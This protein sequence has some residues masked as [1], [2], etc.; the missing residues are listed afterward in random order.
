MKSVNIGREELMFDCLN[1]YLFAF[2]IGWEEES[3]KRVIF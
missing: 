3:L 2:E 1:D